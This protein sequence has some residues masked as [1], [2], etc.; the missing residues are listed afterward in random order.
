V[1]EYSKKESR[2]INYGIALIC[3]G[4]S[5]YRRQRSEDEEQLHKLREFAKEAEKEV[6]DP[7][8]DD[9][10]VEKRNRLLIKTGIL[11]T[12]RLLAKSDSQNVKDAV[13]RVYLHLAT[14]KANR[15]IMVQNGAVSAL[16]SITA[17]TVPNHAPFSSSA[18]MNQTALIAAQALAKLAI[19]LDPTIAFANTAS[20]LVRPLLYLCQSENQLQVFEGLLALTNLASVE[21]PDS[22]TGNETSV[23]ARIYQAKGLSVFQHQQFSE[24]TRI[25]CA[26]T[27]ALCNMVGSIQMVLQ[28]QNR[29]I[30][31][32]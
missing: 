22:A 2:P 18:P 24:N 4:L 25:Q 16:L 17:T 14:D 31:M 30:I 11:P 26:A 21:V 8:D 6:L 12:I 15:G 7:R 20:S 10:A 23:H 19:S 3:C 29:M 1:F 9:S 13:A 5:A 27:E 32:P 28:N